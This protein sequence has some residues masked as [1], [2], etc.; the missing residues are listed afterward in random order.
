MAPKKEPKAKAKGKAKGKAKAK[1]KAAAGEEPAEAGAEA[2]AE[3][4][5]GEDVA[6]AADVAG[7]EQPEAPKEGAAAASEE[8]PKTEVAK[9]EPP[10]VEAKDEK[11]EETKEEPTED[12]KKEAEEAPKQEGGGETSKEGGGEVKDENMKEAD[13]VKKEEAKEEAKEAEKPP[14]FEEEE[15]AK[16]DT[17]PAIEPR[18]VAFNSSES[19]LNALPTAGGRLVTSLNEGGLQY[20]LSGVRSCVGLKSGRYMFECRIVE[21][22]YPEEGRINRNTRLP[23]PRQMLRLGFSLAGGTVMLEEGANGV[24]FDQDGT[25]FGEKTK[26][27]ASK[28]FGRDHIVAVLLNVDE[29]TPHKNT[30]SL[31]VDGTRVSD[32][33]PLPEK[34]IGKPLHPTLIYKNVTVAVNFG[35][36][37]RKPLPFKCRMVSTAAK[38]DVEVS[39]E[40]K[41]KPEVLF[42]VGIPDQGVFDMLDQFLDKNPLYTELSDRQILEWARKS[43]VTRGR[44][45]YDAVDSKDRPG[46]SFGVPLLDDMSVQQAVASVAPVLNRNLVFMEL[47]NNLVAEKRQA[48]LKKFPAEEFKRVALVAVGEPTSDYKAKVQ[49]LMLASKVKAAENEKKRKAEGDRDR[50]R[51]R[52][53]LEDGKAAAEEKKPEEAAEPEVDKPVELTEEEK[54]LWHRKTSVPDMTKSALSKNF[55]SFS[56]PAVEEGFDE[57]RYVWQDAAASSAA[58]KDWLMEQKRTQRI[59]DLQPSAWFKEKLEG[60]TKAVDEWRKKHHEAQG[61]QPTKKKEPKAEGEDGDD[62]KEG[63][64]DAGEEFNEDDIDVFKLEN[65]DDMGNGLPVFCHF[66]YEDWTLLNTRFELHLLVHAFRKDLNDPDRPSFHQSHLSYYYERYFRKQL[67]IELFSVANLEELVAL[68]K[69]NI[70]LDTKTSFVNVVLGEDEPFDKFLRLTEE[71][72]RERQRCIDAGDETARLTFQKPTLQSRDQARGGGRNSGGSWDGGR[73]GHGR[74]GGYNKRPASP[75]RGGDYGSKQGRFGSSSSYQGGGSSRGP[76]PAR[77]GGSYG[78]SHGGADR[79]GGYDRGSRGGDYGRS[80]GGAS[81]YDR[82]GAGGASGYDRGGAGGA[83]RSGGYSSGGGSSKGPDKGRSSG[84]G[85]G[86]GKGSSSGGGKGG[87]DRGSSGGKG[88]DRGG[89]DR[90]GHSRR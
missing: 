9:E 31:F 38:D 85:G 59:D 82:G 69:E 52:R 50:D 42:P 70:E 4:E 19:T 61:K 79:S 14:K 81:G 67:S 77:S 23:M 20:L 49:E 84:G 46:M 58:F 86:G 12:A 26:T 78:S 11:M 29:A 45:G 83:P 66:A 28:R 35:P 88:Y 34:L 1:A 15:D 7:E 32:P 62:K 8:V 41:D 33:E 25:F 2:P 76:P 16:E 60:F 37:P 22:L 56:L 39:V 24:Y 13:E 36:T 6:E 75:S 65:L 5:E 71:H 17:R 72:R 21:S 53:R 68:I 10:K 87:Y 90:G 54:A 73:D 74:D 80:G 43:G 44:D 40:P 57:V 3:G 48:N 51:A 64:A 89:N 18:A 47:K 30:V 63:E 27:R 55:A